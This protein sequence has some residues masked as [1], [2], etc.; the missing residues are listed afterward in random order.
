MLIPI[1][2]AKLPAKIRVQVARNTSQD[3]GE[4]DSLLDFIRGEIEAREVSEKIKAA[5]KQVKHPS[6]SRN[7][8]PTAG[9]FFGATSNREPTVPNCL[10]CSGKSLFCIVRK[11]INQSRNVTEDVSP[12]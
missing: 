9:T 12:A 3:V 7:S 8:L 11:S 2:M 6:P 10:Y 4:I 5:T 1:I